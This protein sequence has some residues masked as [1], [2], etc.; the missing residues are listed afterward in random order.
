M[1]RLLVFFFVLF[2]LQAADLAGEAKLWHRVTLKFEG[3]ETSE[4]AS[5]NPFRDYR[6]N[7]VFLHP[8]SG[9][10]RT[11][12]GHY[13]A[14]G[15]AAET[16]AE[17]G[18]I[19]RVHFS[20]NREGEWRWKVSFR[21][22]PDVAISEDPKAGEAWKPL[23]GQSG[24]FRVG[25]SDK[26]PPDFRARGTLEYVGERYLR[27]AGDG[28]YYLKTGVDSP[29]TLLGYHD[30]D[31]TFLD[32]SE[33]NRPPAPN[34]PIHLPALDQG[35]HHFRP[36]LD[37][38]RPGDPTWQGG[39]GKGLIGGLNYLAGQ[40]VNSVYFLTMN[41]NGDGRN[42]WP[43]IDPWVRDR[44]D[45]S[46]LDQWEIVFEH[47][48]RLGINLHIVTQETENDHLLD[49]GEAGPERTLYYRELV[50]RFAHHPAITWNLGEENV[51]S[52]EQQ[53]A[54]AALLRRLNPYR[55]NIVIHND[56]WH[57][58]NL[59][60]TFDPLLAFPAVTG[61]AIQ[62]FHWNDIH[63]HVLHYVRA[64][65]A[66]GHPWVVCA[67]EMGGANWGTKTDD[68]D[69][70]HDYPRRYGLWGNLMA[71]GAGVEWYFGWQNNSPDSDLSAEDWRT[72]HEMYRQSSLAAGFFQEYLPFHRME[73]A[74][75]LLVGK[76]GYCLAAPGEIY[77]IYLPNGGGTRFNLGGSPG[78]YEVKWF[79]PRKGGR[80]RDG[81]VKRVRGPGLAWTGDPPEEPYQDWAVLARRIP[82][83][84]PAM[85]F[86]GEN[87]QE[88]PPAEL[89]V[90][91]AGLHHALN[92][93]RMATGPTGVDETV[94]VRRGVVIYKGKQA[95]RAHNV[96]SAT[97]SVT[98]TA[99]G[100]LVADGRV[101]LDTPAADL[102]LILRDR[103]RGVT[104]RDFATMTSGYSAVGGSRWGEG[105]EDWSATPYTPGQPLFP[106]GH[107]FAYW[108]EAQMM[109]G[110]VLTR[111]AGRDLLDLLRE[112]IFE[113]IGARVESW[114]A[115]GGLEGTPIRNGCTGL[116][117]SALQ[118]ARFGHLF[119]NKGKW[120]DRVLVDAA[121][122]DQ[123]TRAQV[124]P[125]ISVADTDRK[126]TD[127]RGVYGFNWWTNRGARLDG[128]RLMP[129]APAGT[130]F[131]AGLNHNLCVVIPEWEM[132]I[133]RLGED[134]S[135]S[136]GHAWVL[137]AFLRRLGM[138]VSPLGDAD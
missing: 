107:Q 58:R 35:L 129:D 127:G 91:P 19:W 6:L 7:V 54:C 97:K 45:C 63:A 112:R 99:L 23:D 111:A 100:L 137:N 39:K 66:A 79:D 102:E 105:S 131:A 117:I 98:S 92:Y 15:N 70:T 72:R 59:R 121:W 18:K 114:A 108:D 120:G 13:A 31:G 34:P 52:V 1:T 26:K 81:S 94:I 76:A 2:P 25:P 49:G 128:R 40:G 4:T 5:P 86:P 37:D 27:F 82:E 83:S 46:K 125:G 14:D 42:V 21:T 78:L 88:L 29:E 71:G 50:S 124:P 68:D 116:H 36:H 8:G 135:P 130:Y 89:G 77:A 136:R 122:I 41:V 95:E 47:M 44:F 51:Q 113:P 48:T 65:A 28:S 106:P 60:E 133:V 12:P 53:K 9:E 62:D 118:F 33:G 30:F 134:G 123:A 43:W 115:E 10:A 74:N 56:H 109:F 55:H 57:A 87:W 93:W 119:L 85:Q 16:S 132:V 24:T 103:Y 101:S 138:A 75:E 22:G 3:P 104:L 17:A 61:T 110:R 67:D 69:P 90:D 32:R 38:W 80:P 126:G 96:W 73:P 84:A 11:V 64:S 20:S